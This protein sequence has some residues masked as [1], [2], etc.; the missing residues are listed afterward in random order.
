MPLGAATY[1]VLLVAHS[2]D[3]SRSKLIVSRRGSFDAF[4]QL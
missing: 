1:S 4:Q 3:E 2:E